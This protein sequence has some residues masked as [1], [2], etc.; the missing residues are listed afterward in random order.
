MKKKADPMF[1]KAHLKLFSVITSILLAVFIALLG[2]VNIITKEV[3]EHQSEY[4]LKQ[5]A[6]SIEYND[7]D[8]YFLFPAPTN[9]NQEKM[10]RGTVTSGTT[11]G[12]T[13]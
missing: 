8:N 13:I 5:I 11:S 7:T 9:L 2:S 3:M 1:R 4:V 12:N 6:A 10:M